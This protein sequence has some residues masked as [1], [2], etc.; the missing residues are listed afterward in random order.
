MKLPKE[1]PARSCTIIL[2]T[3]F[4]IAVTYVFFKYALAAILPFALAFL[5][6]HAL[7]PC[8]ELLRMR[9]KLTRRICAGVLV[10]VC[11]AFVGAIAVII[12]QKLYSEA[13]VLAQSISD[14]SVLSFDADSSAI[15]QSFY[16]NPIVKALT[17]WTKTA[18]IDI[19]SSVS[20]FFAQKL[21]LLLEGI[22][23][24]L[25]GFLFACIV[26][27]F[28]GVYFLS[29]YSQIKEFFRS[30]M[31][32]KAFSGFGSIKRESVKASGRLVKGYLLIMLMTFCLLLVG[33]WIIKAKYAF[34][35]ALI[36]AVLDVLPL[37]GTGVVLVPWGIISLS[38]GNVREG[39]TLLIMFVVITV[40]RQLTEPAI[41]G[42]QQGLHPLASMLF[43]YIGYALFGFKGM[44]IAPVVASIVKNTVFGEKFQK[45]P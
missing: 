25:P 15:V 35:I 9:T 40:V 34:I 41:L 28:S 22:V 45:S 42:K 21:P 11:G 2:Y 23:E 5:F 8:Y 13:L 32:K 27:L 1:D 4:G 36:T 18:G 24:G 30:H 16:K 17:K 33:F 3:V 43:I 19:L 14:G 10:T 20:S 7:R 26:F 12:M 29:D 31:S 38:S 44:V 39:A 6:A 37:I